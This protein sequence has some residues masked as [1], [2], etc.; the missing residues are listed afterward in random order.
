MGQASVAL[1]VCIKDFTELSKVH[2][3]KMLKRQYS[4]RGRTFYSQR[5]HAATVSDCQRKASCGVVVIVVQILFAPL[6]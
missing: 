6:V 2:Q 5:L 3:F 1:D 4:E